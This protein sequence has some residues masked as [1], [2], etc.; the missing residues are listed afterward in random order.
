MWG[1]DACE[2][3]AAGI[4]SGKA[5]GRSLAQCGADACDAR[6]PGTAAAVWTASQ[7]RGP[8]LH[9]GQP[10]LPRCC[11]PSQLTHSVLL[12]GS[13]QHTAHRA[14]L[15]IHLHNVALHGD[16]GGG[17]GVLY[18]CVWGGV[19]WVGGWVGGERLLGAGHG[20]PDNQE[21]RLGLPHCGGGAS[22]W[23]TPAQLPPGGSRP[24]TPASGED[25]PTCSSVSL[26]VPA[27][28]VTGMQADGTT[29]PHAVYSAS[30][31]MGTPIA[32]GWAQ[33]GAWGW[34][35]H[36]TWRGS[37]PCSH[38]QLASSSVQNDREAGP[39]G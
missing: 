24:G 23:R 18:V 32:C 16:G 27:S 21:Q 15:H 1:A 20:R 31:L 39:A 9:R 22:G 33:W 5:G 12:R 2:D 38:G 34:Q 8:G 28:M 3:H 4:V 30:R 11:G 6:Q 35:V 37:R 26:S 17:G 13:G 10:G 25:S 7:G 14:R 36:V 19:G 29:P